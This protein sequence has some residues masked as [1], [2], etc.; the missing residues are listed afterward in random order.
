MKTDRQHGT[1]WKLILLNQLL[2]IGNAGWV[3]FDSNPRHVECAT[4]QVQETLPDVRP[5]VQE[6]PG[7]QRQQT[8]DQCHHPRIACLEVGSAHSHDEGNTDSNTFQF[9][10]NIDTNMMSQTRARESP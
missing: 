4:L 1:F 10:M 6:R 3:W 5:D 2:E 7:S 8:V 9:S